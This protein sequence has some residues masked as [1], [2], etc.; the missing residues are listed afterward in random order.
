MDQLD[1]NI[2]NQLQKGLPVCDRPYA[3]VATDLAVDEKTI[4]NRLRKLLDEGQLTRFGPMFNT[5]KMGGA[6]SLVAM[7]VPEK[8][9]NE[10]VAIINAFPEV[11]HNYKRKHAFNLW[12][13]V[14]T[15]TPERVDFVLDK[16][17]E[18]TGFSVYNMP[19]LKEYC[20]YTRFDA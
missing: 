6:Y 3:E 15:D 13:V 7:K 17:H 18:T 11:A 2:I 16:I 1:R 19:K 12:F 8:C 4:I 10:T 20:L 5:E 9:F 14:A